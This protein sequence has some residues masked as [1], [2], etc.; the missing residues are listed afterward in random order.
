MHT[1][2][3][4]SIT[5]PHLNSLFTTPSTDNHDSIL[6]ITADLA[7]AHVYLN[8]DAQNAGDISKK[9]QS[10]TLSL[11]SHR[12]LPLDDQPSLIQPVDPMAWGMKN[13]WVEHDA[14]FSISESGELAFW[15]PEEG[16]VGVNGHK[17]ASTSNDSGW[18]CTGRVKTGRKGIRKAKCSSAKKTALSRFLHALY[19]VSMFIECCFTVAPCSNSEEELTIWDSK[20]SEFASG[21]EFR[22]TYRLGLV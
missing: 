17:G 18:R 12:H 20:E 9:S 19:S 22:R 3:P 2:P 14:L 5:V 21:L 15:V 13:Q 16:N 6:G 8:V 1:S 7:V 10:V 11:H 4:T